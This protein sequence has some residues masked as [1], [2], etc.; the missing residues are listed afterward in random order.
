MKWSGH[1]GELLFAL[2]AR[3][4]GFRKVYP[5]YLFCVV[6]LV[7]LV[8]GAYD[9]LWCLLVSA[10][11]SHDSRGRIHAVECIASWVRATWVLPRGPIPR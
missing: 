8:E 10:L 1:C 9:R 5:S 2:E 6:F 3:V 7:A 11:H 4:A